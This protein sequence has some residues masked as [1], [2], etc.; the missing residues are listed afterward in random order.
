MKNELTI[1]SF[2][3]NL[4]MSPPLRD[5]ELKIHPTI[6]PYYYRVMFSTII[7]STIENIHEY[8]D[9]FSPFFLPPLC[10]NRKVIFQNR[11]NRKL[12]LPKIKDTS[13]HGHV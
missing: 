5:Q 10:S 2:T 8:K 12:T 11:R 13:L 1:S 4:T 3:R 9:P 7:F 6:L